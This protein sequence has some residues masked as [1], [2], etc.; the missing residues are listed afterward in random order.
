MSEFVDMLVDMLPV[1]SKIQSESNPFRMVLDGSLGEYM[2]NV[3]DVFDELFVDSASGGWLDAFGKDFGVSR[4]LGEDDE[5]YRERIILSGLGHLTVDYLHS[6]FGLKVYSYVED[7]VVTEN[8]LISDNEYNKA[9]G[10]MIFTDDLTIRTLESK[11]IL[12]NEVHLR[13]CYDC[14]FYD[15]GVNGFLKRQWRLTARSQLTLKPTTNGVYLENPVSSSQTLMLKK[16]PFNLVSSRD[17]SED[18]VVTFDILE[19]SGGVSFRL[20]DGTNYYPASFNGGVTG[21]AKI[22][23]D[24]DNIKVYV[25]DVLITSYDDLNIENY[26]MA[27]SVNNGSVLWKNFKVVPL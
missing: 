5:S 23:K 10:Y 16:D 3:S 11:F 15:S 6:L 22:I 2:D 26:N 25:D 18:I 12:G 9:N 13:N 8:C 1:N 27:F 21:T 14:L 19:S 7:S 20:Y 4:G 24:T 17:W